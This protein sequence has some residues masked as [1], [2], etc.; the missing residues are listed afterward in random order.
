MQLNAS[1]Q[2]HHCKNNESLCDYVLCDNPGITCV[3]QICSQCQGHPNLGDIRDYMITL[4]CSKDCMQ[5]NINCFEANHKVLQFDRFIYL[6]NGT[7]KKIALVDKH[8]SLMKL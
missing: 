2:I 8:A 1:P 3:L 4:K 6:N 5:N 7:E